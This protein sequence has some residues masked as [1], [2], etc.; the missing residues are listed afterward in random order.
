MMTPPSVL[1]GL[2]LTASMALACECGK[3]PQQVTLEVADSGREVRL[4]PG[5]TLRLRLQV[6]MGTGYVWQLRHNDARLLRSLGEAELES[7]GKTMPGGSEYLVF[8]FQALRRGHVDLELA[9]VRPWLKDEPP[10]KLFSAK[11]AIGRKAP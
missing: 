2:C 6:Q 7:P 4:C 5:D 3:A 10:A 8:R 9:L 11:V 1:L